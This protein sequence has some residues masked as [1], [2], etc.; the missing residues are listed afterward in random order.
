M[1][2]GNFRRPYLYPLL[3]LM[4]QQSFYAVKPTGTV[5]EASSGE[6]DKTA[7]RGRKSRMGKWGIAGFLKNESQMFGHARQ[8]CVPSNPIPLCSNVDA[9]HKITARQVQT[10]A[11]RGFAKISLG[12]WHIL[13]ACVCKKPAHWPSIWFFTLEVCSKPGLIGYNAC[14]FYFL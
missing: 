2:R 3:I 7:W 5:K 4:Y 8:L 12:L 13:L 9:V 14:S 1:G 6:P 10:M 11:K